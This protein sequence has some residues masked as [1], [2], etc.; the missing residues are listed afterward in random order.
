MENNYTVFQS[1]KIPKMEIDNPVF[2]KYALDSNMFDG[3]LSNG[4]PLVKPIEIPGMKVN[5]PE[6]KRDIDFQLESSQNNSTQSNPTQNAQIQNNTVQNTKVNLKPTKNAKEYI[7]QYADYAVDQMKK[8]GIPASITLA[9]GIIE[10][11]SG[12]SRLAREANNHFGI[13]GTYNG[14][15]QLANDDKPNEKFKKYDDPLQSFEDH[16][17]ILMNKRYQIH[18]RGLDPTDY[19]G[20]AYGIKKGGY[21]TAPNYA[22]ALISTIEA[23]G[24]DK[25]D[26]IELGK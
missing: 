15:Y 25:Y 7:E 26:R 17:K 4:I 10:S 14:N 19:R 24:L 21:A 3:V 6:P 9:Q 2:G 18:L 22:Q 11:G 13:K 8:Y 5:N 12:T 23:N 16:S 1:V 20:W